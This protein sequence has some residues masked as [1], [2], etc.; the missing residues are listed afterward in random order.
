LTKREFRL[1]D[2]HHYNRSGP[3]RWIVSHV[4]RYPFLPLAVLLAAVLNN[5]AYSYRQVLVGQAF[6]LI[7]GPSWMTE[8]LLMVSLSVL[9]SALA[10]GVTGLARNFAVE[11]LAQRIERDARDELY[12]SLLGKSQTFHGKQR[13]GD[14]MARA[15]DDVRMLNFM[16]SP[17]LMLITDSLMALVVPIA[18]IAQLEWRLLLV[19]LIFTALLAI[20]VAD[21][22][23]RLKPVSM[24]RR[25]QFG[26]MNAGLAEAIAGI[27]VVKA[28][29][30]ERKEWERF[31]RNARL[32]RDYFVQQG[33]IQARYLPML[34]FTVAWA[35]AFLHAL[36]LWR[37]GAIS[38]G[39]VIAFMGLMGSL[40]FPTFISIFSFNL[41]QLGVAS[42]ERI[43]ELIAAEFDGDERHAGPGRPGQSGTEH[44]GSSPRGRSD[45]AGDRPPP[46]SGRHCDRHDARDETDQVGVAWGRLPASRRDG[47]RV[48]WRFH[49]RCAQGPECAE[50][51]FHNR[52][53]GAEWRETAAAGSVLP[54]GSGRTGVVSRIPGKR[55]GGP[56]GSVLG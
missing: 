23:R 12:A 26:T 10:Q 16:F 29:A 1:E 47:D 41:V 28:N 21:Y 34:A 13:I 24:A 56:D 2:E 14:I 31:A 49:T 48:A 30:Q 6:D 43:M 20:T 51:A 54:S 42:A 7:T 27:E 22:N 53:H 11:F 37:A 35:G 17:G 3:V 15:T 36:L 44:G 4:L 32:F 52:R 5:W 18:L 19:P 8:A 50:D 9:G 38:L 39:Q 33:E 45:P 55:G 40:R 25:E 46:R